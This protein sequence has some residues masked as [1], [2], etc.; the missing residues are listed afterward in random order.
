MNRK[1][2][3]IIIAVAA[4]SLLIGAA[5]GAVLNYSEDQFDNQAL[6][7]LKS[8]E[9]RDNHHAVGGNIMENELTEIMNA[10][11]GFNDIIGSNEVTVVNFF[12]SWCDPCKRETPALNEY[13][14]EHL[15]EPIDIIGI[16]IS[17]S[18][19]NRDAFLEE[20]EVQYPVFEFEDEDQAMS[21]HQIHLMP[22][23]FFVNGEGEIIRAYIG[24]VS[25]ELV[26]NYINYVKEAS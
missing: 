5:I 3:L 6:E 24:E 15:D 10:N 8:T 18:D 25:P 7:T 19:A 22:T 26:T 9:G 20:Y 4:G 11:A 13:H 14:N 21:D 17:D 23:T 2:I 12:A 16:N 1:R